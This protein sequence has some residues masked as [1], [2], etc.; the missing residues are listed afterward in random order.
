MYH[1]FNSD[2][3]MDVG[4]ES[5]IVF[6]KIEESIYFLS[7][8]SNTNKEEHG[9]LRVSIKKEIFEKIFSYFTSKEVEDAVARL[10]DK[11]YI[12]Y[13]KSDNGEIWFSLSDRIEKLYGI[14]RRGA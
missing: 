8:M 6:R 11:D 9:K 2:V 10:V 3:A 4:M 1:S 12:L 13:G 5:A 7:C 14:D